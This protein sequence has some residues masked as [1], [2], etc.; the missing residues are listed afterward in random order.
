[1][2][3]SE[4]KLNF[5]LMSKIMLQRKISKLI[6]NPNLFFYDMFRK[7]LFKDQPL[8]EINKKED[9]KIKAGSDSIRITPNINIFELQ[10]YGI[11]K[12]LQGNLNCGLATSR[13]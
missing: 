6:T 8:Y 11:I 13:W 4:K 1:M 2:I 10:R 7:R 9:K 12:Y 5:Y 3:R